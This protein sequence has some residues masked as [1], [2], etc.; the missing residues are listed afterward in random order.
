M[1]AHEILDGLAA[2]R[3]LTDRDLAMGDWRR[4]RRRTGRALEGLLHALRKSEPELWGWL[5]IL[6]LLARA[7]QAV[8]IDEQLALWPVPA[9]DPAAARRRSRQ[10]RS[11]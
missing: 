8:T 5:S 3:M 4:A 10:R 2:E 6:G 11:R 1:D 7:E 9:G